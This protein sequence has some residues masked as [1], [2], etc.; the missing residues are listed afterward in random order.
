MLSCNIEWGFSAL[1]GI[2]MILVS[3]RLEMLAHEKRP[4]ESELSFIG[5][6]SCD[7]V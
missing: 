7:F 1:F 6:K 2:L 4:F 5:I 3:I